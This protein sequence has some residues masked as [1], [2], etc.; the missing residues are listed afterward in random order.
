M[1]KI[2]KRAILLL[3]ALPIGFN[4]M[5]QKNQK[6]T[7]E[8]L[9]PGGE[10]YL[11]AENLY[12]LQWWGDECIKPGIDTLYS[13]QPQTG[14]EEVLFTRE[15]VNKALAS[16]GYPKLSHL[17]DLQFL[18]DDKTEVLLPRN[19]RYA[20]YNWKK[21]EVIGRDDLPKEPSANYDYAINKNLAYTVKNN[22]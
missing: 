19:I 3:L 8:E 20:V 15:Q 6:P 1:S 4:V 21:G 18:W 2:G 11:Y 5:A 16:A 13:V 17:Y 14:K 22:L 10:S 9:I 7:L 12:G